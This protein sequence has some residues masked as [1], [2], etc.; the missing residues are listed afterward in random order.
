MKNTERPEPPPPAPGNRLGRWVLAAYG[1]PAF[2]QSFLM[3]PAIS[4][5]QGIYAKFFGLGL[6]EIALVLVIARAFN[7]VSDPLIGFLSDATRARL[8][9]RKPW[10]IGGAVVAMFACWFLYVPAG[11]VT[12]LSFLAWFLLADIGWSMLAVPYGAWMAELTDDYAERSRIA[13]WRAVGT[14]AGMLAF[15]GMP[16]V[17]GRFLGTTEFTPDTLRWAAIFAAVV[18]PATVLLAAFVVPNG[19]ARGAIVANPFRGA[20]RAVA[21]N[22]PLWTFL[23]MFAVGGLGGGMGWGLVYFYIDGYLR[24][25]SKLSALLV[26]SLPVA[27][28]ATPAWGSLCRR[29]GKQKAWAAGYAVA[30]VASLSYMLI[31]PGPYAALFLGAALL[32]L[33][34]MVV[35]EGVAAP[36]VLADIVD[37]GRWR[38]GVDHAGTYFALFGMIQKINVG[39][40]AAIGLAIAGAFGFEAA[41]ATQNSG[42]L[43]GLLL[44]FSALPGLSYLV[45]AWM[46]LRF[47]IDRR[48]QQV[49]VKAIARRERRATRTPVEAEAGG[50]P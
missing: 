37:Y 15:F 23:A 43:F 19:T 31:S 21:G 4:V 24:L 10:L 50:A 39:I 20:A 8:G 17:A 42:G 18:L 3:G 33:N 5:L 14:Y 46:V 38:F 22:R 25:G 29:L 9:S 47:P 32:C 35:V 11:K 2:S 40:G 12:M 1:A 36:A 7:G 44:A 45:S 48:R 27:I 13:T 26:L 49:L 28:L 34:A 41:A 30:G 16:M 6:K